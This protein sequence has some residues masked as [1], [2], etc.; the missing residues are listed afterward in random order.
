M[1]FFSRWPE[2]FEHFVLQLGAQN[3]QID[4]LQDFLNRLGPHPGLEDIGILVAQFPA[5]R[6]RQQLQ[7][8]QAFQ[9]V[10][11]GLVFRLPLLDA[12]VIFG[13]EGLLPLLLPLGANGLQNFASHRVH[14][15]RR[16]R[17]ISAR[18]SDSGHPDHPPVA[19]AHQLHRAGDVGGG[20][21]RLPGNPN[22]PL[23]ALAQQLHRAGDVGGDLSR[24]IQGDL[25]QRVARLHFFA[26]VDQDDGVFSDGVFFVD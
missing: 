10:D 25:R 19:L 17:Q 21:N 23:I 18:L 12:L 3:L 20:L 22:P 11:G 1:A 4:P 7:R 2:V 26:I 8:A 14:Q 13:P 15:R 24:N 6:L 5:A 16:S 9:F